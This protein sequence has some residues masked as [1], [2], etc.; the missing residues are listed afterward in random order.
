MQ[1]LLILGI[2]SSS[3][4]S[5]TIDLRLL[6]VLIEQVVVHV[7]VVRSLVQVLQI[8]RVARVFADRRGQL[9]QVVLLDVVRRLGVVVGV[10]VAVRVSLVGQ[11]RPLEQILLRVQ[12]GGHGLELVQIGQS[13]LQ[14]VLVREH[15]LG[16]ALRDVLDELLAG[17]PRAVRESLELGLESGTVLHVAV[18]LGGQQQVL[19]GDFQMQVGELG[20]VT[21][22]VLKVR[23][24]GRAR[25]LL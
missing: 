3:F 23:S 5:P 13:G 1:Q 17:G 15:E 9:A 16:A 6:Q 22:Q 7:D 21:L 25:P 20:Q 24:D 14:L 11:A 8:I 4:V 18:E 10:L 19:V 2:A 12:D